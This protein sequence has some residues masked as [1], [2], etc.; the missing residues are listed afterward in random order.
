MAG[1]KS[2]YDRWLCPFCGTVA[3]RET[4]RRVLCDSRTCSCGAIAL[5]APK[6]DT[7]EIVDDA[8][9]L[10]RVPVRQESRGYDGLLIEDMLRAGVEI[11][12]GEAAQVQEGFWGEYTSMWFRRL[13]SPASSEPGGGPNLGGA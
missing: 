7:D 4:E 11:Q 12:M 13:P 6:V 8:L 2:G 3:T 5:A 9:G 1:I 10:F